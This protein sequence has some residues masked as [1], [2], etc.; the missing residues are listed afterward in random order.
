MNALRGRGHSVTFSC[1]KQKLQLGTWTRTEDHLQTEAGSP[2]KTCEAPFHKNTSDSSG[3]LVLWCWWW[4][5]KCYYCGSVK[6]GTR[7]R[8]FFL[9][10][11][12][13][14]AGSS[15]SLQ[16]APFFSNYVCVWGGGRNGCKFIVCRRES[17]F[18]AQPVT[19]T[20][21]QTQQFLT[22][23]FIF[24]YFQGWKIAVWRH[25]LNSNNL[26]FKKG[27]KI[28]GQIFDSPTPTFP[29]LLRLGS[30]TQSE[31]SVLL[32][33]FFDSWTFMGQTTRR[34]LR[35]AGLQG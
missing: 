6:T 18:T 16:E 4:C 29:N 31:T 7:G 19:H 21:M 27:A 20:A 13:K 10:L 15:H 33:L 24:K 23:L 28:K 35:S 11:C 9:T 3:V 1:I 25:S 22:W 32:F 26:Q 5:F 8:F 2:A 17:R 12:N 14:P 34:A 30:T